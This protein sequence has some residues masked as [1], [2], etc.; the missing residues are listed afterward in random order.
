MRRALP[1]IATL[2]ILVVGC[3]SPVPTGKPPGSSIAPS[4]AT[5][6]APSADAP[7]PTGTPITG[8]LAYVAGMGDPQI[9]LLDL[10]TGESRQLTNLRPEDAEL[11][12]EGPLRPALTC[13]FGPYSLTWSPDGSQLAFTYGSCDTVLFVVSADGNLRRIGDGRGPTWSPDGSRLIYGSN[14]PYMPCADCQD[15]G[16]GELELRIVDI[17]G[18]G[19][20]APF[21]ADGST[22]LGG[23]PSFSPDGAMVAF[24]GP[25]QGGDAQA[26]SATYLIGS[27][28]TGAR[29]IANGGYPAGWLPD[30]RLLI[31]RG[32]EGSVHAVDI[33][34]G[35]SEQ[36]GAAQ[37]VSVSPDGSR[38][39]AWTSDP[40]SG[41]Q[42]LQLLTA[43]GELVGEAPGSF[44][45]W[46]PDA[47]AFAVFGN[48]GGLHLVSRD[49]ELL[50]S[51][52][53]RPVGG[54]ASAA[55][56]PG[57]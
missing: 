15:P 9:F 40:A 44:G 55:W 54:P 5:S 51:Y 33:D 48:D 24:S 19:E 23:S 25:P 1:T 42:V 52:E 39:L 57:S 50:A 8:Q 7:T 37:T 34:S 17:A 31:S 2:A 46:S 53:I 26:F 45:A 4:A 21:T 14:V 11:T 47:R 43:A 22:S 13:G 36:V 12:S 18:G 3:A 10:A 38:S 28:G 16:P 20:P 56:R 41:A 29:L 27:D 6:P 49:G 32:A 35:E 30:G